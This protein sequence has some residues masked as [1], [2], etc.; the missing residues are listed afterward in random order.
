MKQYQ[1]LPF[2]FFYIPEFFVMFYFELH[3]EN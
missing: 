2:P 3:A 1:W